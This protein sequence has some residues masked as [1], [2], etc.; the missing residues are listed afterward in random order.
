MQ[1]QEARPAR[2]GGAKIQAFLELLMWGV[3]D[4]DQVECAHIGSLFGV[5]SVHT[6]TPLFLSL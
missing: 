2:L 4:M 5:V 1:G 6:H 3:D